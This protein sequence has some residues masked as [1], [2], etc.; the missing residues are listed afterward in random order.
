MFGKKKSESTAG[1]MKSVVI[2]FY[3]KSENMLHKDHRVQVTMKDSETN[4]L[5]RLK[6]KAAWAENRNPNDVEITRWGVL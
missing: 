3:L 4:D 1:P 6:E 2:E 5:A